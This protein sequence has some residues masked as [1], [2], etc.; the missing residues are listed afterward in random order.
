M[1]DDYFM[2]ESEKEIARKAVEVGKRAVER[3]KE[4]RERLKPPQKS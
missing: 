2:F 3:A 4:I 1:E